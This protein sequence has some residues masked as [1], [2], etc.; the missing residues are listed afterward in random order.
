MA[1][2]RHTDKEYESELADL[3]EQ[4]LLMG[5]KVEKAVERAIWSFEEGDVQL[6]RR[7]IRGDS[8]IDRLETAVDGMALRILAKRQ[9]VASDLRFIAT[10]LKVVTDLERIGDLGVNIAERVVELTQSP[11]QRERRAIL[12][13]TDVAL[14]MLHDALDAFVAKDAT[15]AEEVLAR[16]SMVDT[17]YAQLFR[18]LLAQIVAEPGSAARCTRL[19]SIAKCLERVADHSTNLAEMVVFMV[20]GDDVRHTGASTPGD[21]TET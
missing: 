8:E 9:P 6:A 4:L 19:Q 18:T 15:K 13:I 14:G 11:P 7:V 3:R 10:A 21:D 2:L 1:L 12:S 20:R 5:A 16:D 17:A